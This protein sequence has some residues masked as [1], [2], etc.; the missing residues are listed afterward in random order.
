M[1]RD[2]YY[3]LYS[4]ECVV[5]SFS[6]LSSG[7]KRIE[8]RRKEDVRNA[9]LLHVCIALHVGLCVCICT[10]R[11]CAGVGTEYSM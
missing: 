5:Y 8:R 2:A 10:R 3:I 11:G 9:L 1:L 4:V 6:H 7:R